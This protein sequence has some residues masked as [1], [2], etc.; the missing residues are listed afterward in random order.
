[1]ASVRCS[2]F[3]KHQRVV[4]VL[5]SILVFHY[6]AN[7]KTTRFFTNVVYF[8][9]P[10][11]VCLIT[12]FCPGGELFAVLDRQ[13]M[14]IFREECARYLFQFPASGSVRT[15]HYLKI[16]MFSKFTFSFILEV[17]LLHNFPSM[18]YSFFYK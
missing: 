9:T 5:T 13:P 11:H 17:Y 3:H 2:S 14:K 4:F 18:E 15:Y 7:L 10:T 1:M 12:N 16:M 6:P 8:Q